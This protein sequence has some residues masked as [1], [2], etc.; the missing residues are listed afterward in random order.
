[1]R[2]RPAAV[3]SPRPPASARRQY[4]ISSDVGSGAAVEP[5]PAEHR[6]V[7]DVDDDVPER[8]TGRPVVGRSLEERQ[9]VGARLVGPRH[10]RPEVG[11]AGLDRLVQGLGLVHAVAVECGA[12]RREID[13]LWWPVHPPDPVPPAPARGPAFQRVASWA[14]WNA[15]RASSLNSTKRTSATSVGAVRTVR[16]ATSAAPAIGHP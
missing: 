8:P 11:S 3:A 15:A 10:P 13:E 12:D 14:R 4:P 2:A 1:M 9:G 5:C 16:T 7:V 6:V